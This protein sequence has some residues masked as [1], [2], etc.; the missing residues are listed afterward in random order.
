MIDLHYVP[1]TASAVADMVFSWP[2]LALKLAD[3]SEQTLEAQKSLA[4]R[5][6]CLVQDRVSPDQTTFDLTDVAGKGRA[7]CLG[8]TQLYY[9]LGKSAGLQVTPV[10]V[11]E[12][13]K[14]GQ[15]PSGYRHVCCLVT[16]SDGSTV[17]VNAA[18][19]VFVSPPFVFDE[20]YLRS[21]SYHKLRNPDNPLGLYRRIQLL[22]DRG[23]AAHVDNSRGTALLAQNRLDE[24][25]TRFEQAVAGNAMFAEAWNN[26]AIA[27]SRRGDLDEALS[28]YNRAL[29]IDG[30]YAEAYYNRANAYSKLGEYEKA[31]Q[32][33]SVAI[34]LSPRMDQAYVNRALCYASIGQ[35]AAA[36]RDLAAAAKLNPGRGAVELVARIFDRLRPKTPPPDPSTGGK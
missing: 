16:L 28:L 11:L 15:F 21:G 29:E 31:I 30:D 10:G 33:Y 17:L 2:S 22:D 12:S 9:I 8:Y 3:P 13:R 5:I 26:R 4:A 14:P 35:R 7:N 25:L 34:G 27:R 19:P 20:V 36:Q 23:L 1:E 24:A 32:D 18:P 6:V